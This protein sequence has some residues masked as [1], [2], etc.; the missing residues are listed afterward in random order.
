MQSTHQCGFIENRFDETAEFVF[1]HWIIYL[2]DKKSS[3]DVI[4][5]DLCKQVD[6]RLHDILNKM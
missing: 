6:L 4:T 1:F 5:A 2:D 3:V